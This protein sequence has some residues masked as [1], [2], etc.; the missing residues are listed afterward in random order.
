[1]K[2]KTFAAIALTSCMVLSSAFTGCSLVSTNNRLDMEQ[3][4]ATVDISKSDEFASEFSDYKDAI[5]SKQI[6]KRELVSY[7]LNV[8]YSYVQNGSSYEE[9]FN[10]LVDALVNNAVLVQYSTAALLKEADATTVADFKKETD[11]VKKYES[12]L[13]DDENN[14]AVNLAKYKLYSSINSAIDNYEKRVIDEEDGYTGSGT[15]TTPT[16]LDTEQDDY[17]P[18][19]MEGEKKVLDYG[20]YTGYGKYSLA[21]SGAYKD[22]ALEGGT[23]STRIKAYNSF[24]NNL[25]RNN[26]VD[27]KK[28]AENLTNILELEYIKTEYVSQLESRIINKYYDIYEEKQEADL[29]D[30][31]YVRNIYDGVFTAQKENY[32]KSTSAFDSAMSSMSSSSFILYSPDTSNSDWVTNYNADF[33]KYGFIYNILLPFNSRQ[34]VELNRLKSIRTADGDDD[35]YFVA[36]NELLK[37]IQTEDQRSAWFN[38]ETDY[39]FKPADVFKAEDNFKYYGGDGREYL[40]FENNL[41]N[42]DEGGRYKKLQAYEGKYSYNGKVIQNKD[43][44]YTLIP[45]KLNIDEMLDEFTK[46]V[47][48]V[49]D[50]AGSVG[51]IN[52][53]NSYYDTKEFNKVV[54]GEKTDD[55][56]YSLFTYATGQVN[57]GKFSNNYL[58]NPKSAQYKAMS[59]VNELQFA[60]TTDTSVLSNYIGYSV[61]AYDTSYIKEFEYAAK[62]AVGRGPGSFAVCAG[63]YGW[64]LIYVTYVFEYDENKGVYNIDWDSYSND[65]DAWKVAI[66]EE[67]TFI[68]LFYE[69]VKSNNLTNISTKRRTQIINEFNKDTTVTKYQNRYQDLLDIKN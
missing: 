27:G 33:A 9:T 39:S 28:E 30:A 34:T 38:G 41:T 37:N 55:I 18:F 40:F 59:A 63:D 65:T 53:N 42:S 12:L 14:D 67:G 2:K 15:R 24:L 44:S 19:K 56:D 66:E 52:F 50:G 5:S 13:E 32:D 54:N 25:R 3:V 57:F 26:L 1:M 10:A 48:F 46:Y 23:R 6:I 69:W 11:E 49:L 61:T 62:E 68:N 60:Y 35:K 7:F 21:N 22:D 51:D 16:N 36:R 4:I 29:L 20:I 45:N 58:M 31:S 64:H 43:E 47:N 8:G 17:Y